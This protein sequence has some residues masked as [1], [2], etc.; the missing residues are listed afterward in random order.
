MLPDAEGRYP[1]LERQPFMATLERAYVAE[2]L[3]HQIDVMRWLMGPL[4]LR[5]A[6][7]AR[8]CPAIRGDDRATLMFDT[9]TGV[10]V[11]V[12][13]DAAAAGYPPRS[14]D[15]LEIVGERATLRL[16]A[17][18]LAIMGEKSEITEFDLV[19]GYQTSFDTCIRH[20]VDALAG[21]TPFET[22]LDD[23]LET[24]RLVEDVYVH[25]RWS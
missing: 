2:S 24:L 3:I 19:A 15:A 16:D 20:F 10:P 12:D 23:N 4:A 7:L 5:S 6:A 25:A 22:G 14:T 1:A 9:A 8:R 13:G 21:G 17:G 18:R 11:V